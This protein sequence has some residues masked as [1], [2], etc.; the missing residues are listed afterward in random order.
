MHK[1]VLLNEVLE[2]LHIY[3]SGVYVD[4]TLGAG[5]HSVEIVKRGGFV[6][7]IDEDPIMAQFAGGELEKTKQKNFKIINDNFVNIDRIAEENG[8]EAIDGALLDLGISSVHLDTVARGFSFKRLEE[9]LDMRLSPLQGVAAYDL[10]NGLRQ[11]QLRELFGRVMDR[12]KA[13]VLARKI[14]ERRAIK[15]IKTVGDLVEFFQDTTTKRIHPATKAF[16]A[17]RIAV[18]SEIENLKEALQKFFELLRPG[19]R[20][21]VISF[22][23]LE[24]EVV[25]HFY[26]AMEV[27][28]RGL[29][30]TKKPITP[31]E[32]EIAENKRARSA[33]LRVLQKI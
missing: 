6:L 25:K 4:G 9:P 23:S 14:V 18:N 24:D 8:I 11:D 10:V 5:G 12:G 28:G 7:G 22:H 29:V 16:L 26:K 21:L 3:K 31:D 17:L 1:P 15:P 27:D 30:I 2:G 20:L 32:E 19:G 13:T 33:K